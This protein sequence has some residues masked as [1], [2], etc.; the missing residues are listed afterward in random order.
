MNDNLLA[1]LNVPKSTDDCESDIREIINVSR[2]A[3]YS[4]VNV[5]L[6]QR[7][8]LIGKRIFEEAM[9]GNDR[10]QYGANIILRLSRS[11]SLE[12]GK[13]FGKT[14]LYQ[15]YP[16]LKCILKFSNQ[17]LENSQHF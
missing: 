17:R 10:A 13:G 7:N 9:K 11:L 8:W 14:S 16:F 5:L 2:T 15:F 6:V 3:A 1:K 12:F 4:S